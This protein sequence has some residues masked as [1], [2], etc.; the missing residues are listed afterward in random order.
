MNGAH[1]MG[2]LQS[3]GP[4]N[5]VPEA[6]EHVFHAEW[7]KRALAL[8][9]T[10]S[11]FGLWNTDMSR[12]A[13]ERQLPADYL[14]HSYYENRLAGLE[15]LIVEAGLVSEDEMSSGRAS[16]PSPDAIKKQILTVERVGRSARGQ[17]SGIDKIDAE[18]HF[19][20][21]DRVRA[22]NLH[23]KGH[24]RVPR[25][26][27]GHVGTVHKHYGAQLFADLRALGIDEARH[28]YAV[29]FE[30]QELWGDSA[31]VRSAVYVDL[32]EDYLEPAG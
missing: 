17:T 16:S 13:K 32:W 7:E 24:T 22:I 14:R 15:T 20:A 27:R 28:V 18:P 21:G 5:P 19:R 3:F 23:T 30:G 2:G 4:V 1:D 10:M 9:R 31:N 12:Y 29:R 26:V 8:Q 25:Y 11:V 6:E